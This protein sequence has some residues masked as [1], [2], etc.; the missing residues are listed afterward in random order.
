M[1]GFGFFSGMFPADAGLPSLSSNSAMCL[2]L[3]FMAVTKY[4][5]CDATS[6]VCLNRLDWV[7]RGNS[8][9]IFDP[10][11]ERVVWPPIS[12][13]SEGYVS[14]RPYFTKIIR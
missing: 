8:I 2:L 5:G 7:P 6:P 12:E 14:N 4:K 10:N 13:R 1:V 3:A 11:S 9:I